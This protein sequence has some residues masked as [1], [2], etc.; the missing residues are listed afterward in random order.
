MRV[1]CRSCG[2]HLDECGPLS[3]RGKCEDC[4]VAGVEAAVTAMFA[5]QGPIY[6]KWLQN[7]ATGLMR[8]A[9][10]ARRRNSS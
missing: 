1:T 9:E 5:G 4:G 2:R 3:A 10:R 7:T 6:D 8:A